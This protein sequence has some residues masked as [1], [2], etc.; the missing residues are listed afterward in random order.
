MEHSVLFSIQ[1][2]ETSTIPSKKLLYYSLPRYLR[3]IKSDKTEKFKFEL[4]KFL[5]FIPDEPKMLN[6]VTAA[7]SNGIPDQQSQF[8][9]QGIY[10]GG[11]WRWWSLRIGDGAV[12]AVSKPLQVSR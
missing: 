11:P 1:Q 8:R 10:Q 4:D 12:L 9:A 2:T 6:Y 3:N 5:G 7:R